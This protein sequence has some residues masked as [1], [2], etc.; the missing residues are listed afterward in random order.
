MNIVISPHSDDAIFSIGSYLSTKIDVIIMSPF[1]GIPN[2]EIGKVKHIT[3]NYEHNLACQSMLAKHIDGQ[4]LDD[5][6]E[7]RDLSNLKPWFDMNI[8]E[9]ET[10]YVPL[11]IHHPDHVMVSNLIVELLL[12]RKYKEWYFYEELPYKNIYPSKAID[13][14]NNI[15]SIVKDI[16]WVEPIFC[17][18]KKEKAINFYRSQ[19]KVVDVDKFQVNENL[20]EDL[21]TPESIFKVI[22]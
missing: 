22:V 21:R 6:Y 19:I 4:F 9:D 10:I 14:F 12:E 2:D 7:D 18:P 17:S 16:Q 3:L 13:R 8:L 11:G 5:V 1:M 20:I 15:K